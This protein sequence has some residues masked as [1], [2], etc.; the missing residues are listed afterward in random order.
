[1]TL[2]KYSPDL[3]RIEQVFAKLKHLG[4]GFVI[5]TGRVE[6]HGSTNDLTENP[7]IH[8]AYLGM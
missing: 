6:M 8:Q 1:L 3:N 7:A 2:P 4:R 5:E